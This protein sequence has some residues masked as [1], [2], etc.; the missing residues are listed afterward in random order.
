MAE[1]TDQ[2]FSLAEYRSIAEHNGDVFFHWDLKADTL[3]TYG[4]WFDLLGFIPQKTNLSQRILSTQRIH[5]HDLLSIKEYLDIISFTK[6]NRANSTYYEKIYLRIKNSY[7][8]YIPCKAHVI[9]RFSE[10]NLPL[11]IYGRLNKL[12]SIDEAIYEQ[13][14]AQEKDRL[15]GILTY[16]TFSAL[17]KKYIK[18]D[19]N[20]TPAALFAV[21]VSLSDNFERSFNDIATDAIIA[22]SADTLTRNFD[23]ADF[24]CRFEQRTYLIFC[25]NIADLNSIKQKAV[26]LLKSLNYTF[27]DG[28]AEYTVN[29]SIGMA[30]YPDYHDDESLS[31]AALAACHSA[32]NTENGYILSETSDVKLKSPL[33]IINSQS[34]TKSFFSNFVE[35]TYKLLTS[36]DNVTGMINLL[37][38]IIGR[39][40]NLSRVFIYQQDEYGRYY[41]KT[42]E[43]CTSG[44]RPISRDFAKLSVL[45]ADY[46]Y[47]K[48]SRSQLYICSDIKT[49]PVRQQQNFASVQVKS[50]LRSRFSKKQNNLGCIGFDDCIKARDWTIAEQDYIRFVAEVI[51]N[52]LFSDINAHKIDSLH[53]Q[54][55]DV[56]NFLPVPAYVIEPR[57][58]EL[59]FANIELTKE[60]PLQNG[61]HCYERIYGQTEQCPRC[62]VANNIFQKI[63]WQ[64]RQAALVTKHNASE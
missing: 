40:F 10:Q 26:R 46:L 22:D 18:T 48:L 54:L 47:R 11:C 56:L 57:K 16:S 7:G 23:S 13:K 64:G 29:S 36:N 5:Q 1:N 60:T 53:K 44:I 30:L 8:H 33:P 61:Q 39:H 62:P 43:W 17:L 20:Q 52:A 49:L 55:G 41:I 35:Y 37:L 6:H 50:F 4:N 9:T 2:P 19:K 28:S 51:L 24:I 31:A 38:G 58:L 3:S 15:T 12:N 42:H 14:H 63:E 32:A 25:R 27:T 45:E 34:I 59:L 21:K